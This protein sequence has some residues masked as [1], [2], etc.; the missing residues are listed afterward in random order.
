MRIGLHPARL[1]NLVH[2]L[3]QPR[4]VIARGRPGAFVLPRE[5]AVDVGGRHRLPPRQAAEREPRERRGRVAHI[6]DGKF[7]TE[8]STKN[9][10]W[11][12]TFRVSSPMVS[13]PMTTEGTSGVLD[14][15]YTRAMAEANGSLLSRPIVKIIRI[16]PV[17]TARLQMVIAISESI[18]KTSPTVPPSVAL[19]R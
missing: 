17:C 8:V 13:A 6:R 12:P 16:P 14:V 9:A 18:R 2:R 15:P 5:R 19:T 10:R 11:L 7:A 3:G 1:Q 4:H